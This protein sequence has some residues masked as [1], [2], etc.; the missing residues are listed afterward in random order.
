VSEVA[1]VRRVDK[2]GICV[3]KRRS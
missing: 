1:V 3:Q 2:E